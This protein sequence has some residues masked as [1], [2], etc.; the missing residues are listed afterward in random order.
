MKK[1][2]LLQKIHKLSFLFLNINSQL[3][4]QHCKC[5]YFQHLLVYVSIVGF[6]FCFQSS[7]FT[8]FFSD[9]LL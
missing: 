4:K 9:I 3:S 2:N 1:R 7:S 5:K 8:I 6:L